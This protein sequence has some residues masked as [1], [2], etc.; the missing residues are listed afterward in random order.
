MKFTPFFNLLITTKYFTQYIRQLKHE[1]G[2]PYC[3]AR[4][5]N[6]LVPQSAPLHNKN[7]V[8][9]FN[10]GNTMS[11]NHDGQLAL[12]VINSLLYTSFIFRIQ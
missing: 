5:D 3:L 4:N 10:S 6:F 7:F 9:I 8:S 1:I 11:N 2:Y 12:E